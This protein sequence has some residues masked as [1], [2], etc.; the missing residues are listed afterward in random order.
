MVPE[1]ALII[2]PPVH[3]PKYE[4]VGAP[5]AGGTNEMPLRGCVSPVLPGQNPFCANG[6]LPKRRAIIILPY[7]D[8]SSLRA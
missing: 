8:E 7:R 2:A 4:T 3:R 1:A 5:R 6:D